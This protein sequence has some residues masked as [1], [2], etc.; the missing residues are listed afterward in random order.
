VQSSDI[1][2]A[3][4]PLGD[5]EAPCDGDVASV[6]AA[7]S[8]ADP[9][10]SV[11]SYAEILGTYF[12]SRAEEALYRA[13]LLSQRFIEA[14]LG[15]EEIIAVHA[16]A[17]EVASKGLGYRERARASTDALQFLL[18]MMIAYGVQY[19]AYLELRLRERERETEARLD[20]ERQRALDAEESEREKEEILATI[21]HELRTPITAAIGNIDLARRSLD[22]QQYERLPRQITAARDALGRLSRLTDDLIGASRDGLP[23][24][25]LEPI[26]AGEVLRQA[27]AWVKPIADEKQIAITFD[28]DG[29]CDAIAD[30]DALL[31]VFGN[32]LSNAVRYTPKGGR[33]E[34]QCGVEGAWAWFRVTD[35]GIGM[36]PETRARIFDKFYRAPD[37]KVAEPRGL[38]LGLAITQRLVAAHHGHLDVESEPGQGSTFLIR[39][40]RH[41]TGTG[42]APQDDCG[43]EP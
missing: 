10:D 9:Q 32:L 30:S 33:V 14:G 12:T 8:P 1:V 38:G 5:P 24:L 3:P 11:R 23:S 4:E 22:R 15:P 37:V 6:N 2:A 19:R 29:T 35:S 31:T 25:T 36:T 40:P 20:L 13:S 21:S 18:E 16:E 43:G 27:C 26:D 42:F 17:V 41:T 39:L 28:G 7:G 34:A